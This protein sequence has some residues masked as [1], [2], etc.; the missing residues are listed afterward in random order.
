[1]S[2]YPRVS[3]IVPVFNGEEFI[4]EAIQSVLDQNYPNVEVIVVD[5]GST[6]NTPTL[7]EKY[8]PHVMTIRQQNAGQSKALERGWQQA[9]GDIIGYL[10]AD[11]RLHPKAIAAAVTALENNPDSVLAYPDFDIIDENSV[12][13]KTVAASNYQRRILFGQLT[14]IAGPGAFFWKSAYLRAGP[15]RSDLRHIPDLE[16]FLRMALLGDFVRVPQVLADFRRHSGSTTYRPAA[17]ERGEESLKMLDAFYAR[18]DIPSDVRR[19]RRF[20]YSNAMLLSAQIHA[21]SGRRG[22]ALRRI[23]SSIVYDPRG[24]L[25]KRGLSA[26]L[27]TLRGRNNTN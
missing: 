17:F 24:L 5:D 7:L 4:G 21:G 20:A 3:L 26:M 2:N 13:Q 6:D 16:F 1:M 9:A 18:Q 15:W 22:T 23:A 14:T 27:M 25:S 8:R 19:W 11:D 12:R 10:S